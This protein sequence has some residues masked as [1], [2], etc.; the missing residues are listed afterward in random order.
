M[1][2]SNDRILKLENGQVTVTYWDAARETHSS[3]G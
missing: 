2:L 1:A 3:E